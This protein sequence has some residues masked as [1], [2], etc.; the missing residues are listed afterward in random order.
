MENSKLHINTNINNRNYNFDNFNIISKTNIK[1]NKQ[2]K[3][4]IN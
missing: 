1:N 2:D 4:E 3:G